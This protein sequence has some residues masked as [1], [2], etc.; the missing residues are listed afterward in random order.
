MYRKR[1]IAVRGGAFQKGDA[2]ERF[3]YFDTSY[4]RMLEIQSAADMSQTKNFSKGRRT[5]K[6]RRF[7]TALWNGF[8]SYDTPYWRMLE[9]QSAADMSQ[10]KN[11]S[12]G[13][14]T[15]KGRRFG[16]V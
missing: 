6:G 3:S 16:T 11:F 9:I 14:R 10:T 2:L 7:G 1:K 13:R 12:K 5:P 15:P 4:S 8:L